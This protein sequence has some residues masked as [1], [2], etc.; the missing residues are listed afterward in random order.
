MTFPKDLAWITEA[1]RPI[2]NSARGNRLT[3]LC[4]DSRFA[5]W[6]QS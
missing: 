6:M 5:T 4:E 3:Y 2:R 1:M